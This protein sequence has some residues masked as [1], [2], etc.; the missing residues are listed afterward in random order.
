MKLEKSM[1]TTMSLATAMGTLALATTSANAVILADDF[2][3]VDLTT[4]GIAVVAGGAWDTEN[5]VSADTSIL[6]NKDHRFAVF[7]GVINP[8]Q[9]ANT[10]SYIGTISLTVMGSDIN[11][12][13]LDLEYKLLD[14]N[15]NAQAN[16]NNKSGFTTVKLDGSGVIGSI[17][18]SPYTAIPGDTNIDI[19]R[20]VD[21][22]GTTLLANQSYTLTIESGGDGGDGHFKSIDSLTLNGDVVVPEPSSTA[23]LGLGGL[24]LLLRRRK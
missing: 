15:G 14:G 1:K 21:L 18:L 22:T 17:P 7:A 2:T 9:Y 13:S 8:D 19:D 6:L 23:L 5:G 10:G 11:L 12:T 4:D 16:S 20:S 24:A 3:G